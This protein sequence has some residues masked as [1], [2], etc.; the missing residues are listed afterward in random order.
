MINGVVTIATH[1]V[2]QADQLLKGLLQEKE[3]QRETSCFL[4][5]SNSKKSLWVVPVNNI[6]H[7][8]I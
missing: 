2:I 4:V 7:G 8:L 5:N 1:Y 3:Q 6:H